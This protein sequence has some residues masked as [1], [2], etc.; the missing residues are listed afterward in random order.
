MANQGIDMHNWNIDSDGSV[1]GPATGP[2]HKRFGFIDKN[3]DVLNKEGNKTGFVD[4]DGSIYNHNLTIIGWVDSDGQIYNS[5]NIQIGYVT[6]AGEV[7][8]IKHQ[9]RGWVNINIHHHI[10]IHDARP[11]FMRAGAAAFVLI[12]QN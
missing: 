4:I 7:Y 3:G 9:L 2:D 1:T 6:E 11:M 10:N 12:F 8:N 5:G